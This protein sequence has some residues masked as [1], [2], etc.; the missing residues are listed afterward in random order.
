[1]N[2]LSKKT[3]AALLLAAASA[4]ALA[5]FTFGNEE[6]NVTVYGRIDLGVVRM[7]T[8]ASFLNTGG[9]SSTA[10]K[11]S[12]SPAADSWFGVN[13]EMSLGNGMK[14]YAKV[15]QRFRADTG[16]SSNSANQFHGW[17]YLGL[18][19]SGLG[20]VELGRQYAP[21]A[22]AAL[23]ADPFR[24]DTV[25][26]ISNISL[27]QAGPTGS[28]T[29]TAYTSTDLVRLKNG[30]VVRSER[31][32]GVQASWGFSLAENN[33]AI[34]TGV[35]GV[36]YQSSGYVDYVSGPLYAGIGIDRTTSNPSGANASE[37][38]RLVIATA[39]YDFGVVKPILSITRAKLGVPTGVL[40]SNVA[41]LGLTA[42]L[43]GGELKA[44][45]AKVNQSGPNAQD[46][47][48]F[49]VGYHYFLKRVRT[50]TESYSTKLYIDAATSKASNP[51]KTRTTG[52]DLGVMVAF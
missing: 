49:G 11:S 6:R 2:K 46:L 38:Q 32:S 10:G 51:T 17:S 40:D 4:P 30:L 25:A 7:G 50:G 20:S 39:W 41:S 48:K 37:G 3:C 15:Q 35:S 45:V 22:F 23:N 13:A 12:V 47:T 52:V 18:S 9:G 8:G 16:G 26:T 42:P 43:V 24:W 44:L 14:S 27:G 21:A 31:M 36:G 19:K 33:A 1:M 5:D 34:Q 28:A 29:G